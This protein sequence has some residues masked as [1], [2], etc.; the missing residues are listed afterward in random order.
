[1]GSQRLEHDWATEQLS[2][3]NLTLNLLTRML[4]A[5]N[6]DSGCNIWHGWK[7]YRSCIALALE[8]NWLGPDSLPV[9][10]YLPQRKVALTAAWMRDEQPEEEETIGFIHETFLVVFFTKAWSLG[11]FPGSPMVKTSNAVTGSI[12]GQAAKILHASWPKKPKHK[13]IKQKHGCNKFNEGFLKWS[14]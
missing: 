4:C 10:W 13:A 6:D 9:P 3:N 1:M 8:V 7:G 2:R 14:T 5:L 11:D 12:P